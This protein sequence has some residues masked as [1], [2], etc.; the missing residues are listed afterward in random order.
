M[1]TFRAAAHERRRSDRVTVHFTHDSGYRLH[2]PVYD[3]VV[4]ADE[5]TST[6]SILRLVDPER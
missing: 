3:A 5:L 6:L 4:E 1:G 2:E